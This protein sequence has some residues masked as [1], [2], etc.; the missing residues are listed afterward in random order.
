MILLD[1]EKKIMNSVASN[2]SRLQEV[3]GIEWHV[4]SANTNALVKKNPHTDN[5]MQGIDKVSEITDTKRLS[6]IHKKTA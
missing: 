6:S 1:Y 3:Q 2:K 4:L 5:A